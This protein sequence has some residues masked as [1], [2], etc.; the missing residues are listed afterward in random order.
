[1]QGQHFE[2]KA[3]QFRFP[4]SLKNFD[5]LGLRL[6]IIA[7]KSRKKS[8]STV[9]VALKAAV[10]IRGESSSRQRCH[11]VSSFLAQSTSQSIIVPH[12]LRQSFPTKKLITPGSRL[13]SLRDRRTSAVGNV[14]TPAVASPLAKV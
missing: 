8:I 5:D 6:R 7:D 13:I 3:P 9:T 10:K 14:A 4:G 11:L 1:M 2:Q 12:L